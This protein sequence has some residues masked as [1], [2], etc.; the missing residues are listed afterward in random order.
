[1]LDKVLKTLKARKAKKK[2]SIKRPSTVNRVYNKK[3]GIVKVPRTADITTLS[4]THSL[5]KYTKTSSSTTM[6]RRK[7]IIDH[8]MKAFNAQL[9]HPQVNSRKPIGVP[10]LSEG[11]LAQYMH[12]IGDI[13]YN[14]RPKN[15]DVP[16]SSQRDYC[17]IWEGWKRENVEMPPMKSEPKM[18][19]EPNPNPNPVVVN[20]SS[21]SVPPPSN[22]H[23]SDLV[24]S[25]VKNEPKS[26]PKPGPNSEPLSLNNGPS[27]TIFVQVEEATRAQNVH[28]K[29]STHDLT[30]GNEEFLRQNGIKSAVVD[31][32][33]ITPDSASTVATPS[34]SLMDMDM[35]GSQPE[36]DELGEQPV[37]EGLVSVTPINSSKAEIFRLKLG[38]FASTV[39]KNVNGLKREQRNLIN[40][41]L[42]MLMDF[43][44]FELVKK[45]GPEILHRLLECYPWVDY[46][47]KQQLGLIFAAYATTPERQFDFIFHQKYKDK[48]PPPFKKI[49]EED[50]ES[51]KQLFDSGLKLA[52]DPS[53]TKYFSNRENLKGMIELVGLRDPID[54]RNKFG[55]TQ[56][57]GTLIASILT[58]LDAE[59]IRKRLEQQDISAAA[60]PMSEQQ[61]EEISAM[62]PETQEVTKRTVT[63]RKPRTK[64]KDTK[65]TVTVRKP[66]T[67]EKDT[68]T[69]VTVQ[70]RK[71]KGTN[72]GRVANQQEKFST[73]TLNISEQP[74]SFSETISTLPNVPSTTPT[75]VNT[76]MRKT[77]NKGQKVAAG[78]GFSFQNGYGNK[79]Y[80]DFLFNYYPQFMY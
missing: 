59:D 63:V 6:G 17:K 19:Q 12:D 23:E 78:L 35:V 70:K 50:K 61:E 1:M 60:T 14:L 42:S 47:L 34:V 31:H 37:N 24:F 55:L 62:I 77:K 79:S 36:G 32:R 39:P 9:S 8:R 18:K 76:G 51:L 68:K 27:D 40:E 7:R 65:T 57:F 28:D 56:S 52:E 73:T 2:G 26:K 80:Q 67:E 5:Q 15:E 20:T 16:S 54:I 43:N 29:A 71:N 44:D 4:S 49:P 38:E 33:N 75:S 3:K 13:P 11:R 10:F 53:R 25:F 22:I 58:E 30:K 69:T 64:E 46:N 45:I 21:S 66:R 41:I 74:E 48:I 72:S